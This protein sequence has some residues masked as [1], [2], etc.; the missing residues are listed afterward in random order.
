MVQSK[1]TCP[2]CRQEA[3]VPPGGVKNFPSNFFVNRMMDELIFNCKEDN[4]EVKCDRC[5]EDDPVVS[6]C[7]DCNYFLCQVCNNFHKR[8]R[9]SR[10]HGIVPLKDNKSAE[11]VPGAKML[12]CREHGSEMLYYCETCEELVCFSC[13]VKYHSGHE[14]DTIKR[15]ASKFKQTFNKENGS[16]IEMMMNNYSKALENVQTMKELVKRQG[17]EVCKRIDTSYDALFERLMEQRKQLILQVHGA[18]ATK[19]KALTIQ[20]DEIGHMLTQLVNLKEMNKS[21]KESNNDQETLLTKKRLDDGMKKVAD[22]HKDLNT[23]PVE[24]D[25]MQFFPSKL[26]L[27]Q[28][29]EVLLDVDPPFHIIVFPKVCIQRCQSRP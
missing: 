16:V 1:I 2:E 28:I 19:E 13:T 6:Y 20:M 26:S 10:G 14:H 3:T 9:Q 5:D 12:Q 22:S 15:M 27:P 24:M 21:M 25:T 7:P 4:V 18:M 29:G 11:K 17:K 23:Q 8:D